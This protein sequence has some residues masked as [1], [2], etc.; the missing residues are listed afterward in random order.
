MIWLVLWSGLPKWH[1]DSF[2]PYKVCFSFT[3][4]T[5]LLVKSACDISFVTCLGRWNIATFVAM[6]RS[7]NHISQMKW[8]LLVANTNALLKYSHSIYSSDGR[9]YQICL[10]PRWAEIY[11]CHCHCHYHC[12]G[13]RKELK[14]MVTSVAYIILHHISY[15]TTILQNQA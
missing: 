1:W 3:S 4:T 8:A 7:C 10:I 6:W 2:A 9:G 5:H 12:Q 13:D 14:G 11:V 15:T